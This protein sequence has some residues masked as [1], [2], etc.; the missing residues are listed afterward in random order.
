MLVNPKRIALHGARWHYRGTVSSTV[1]RILR[2]T[3]KTFLWL[4]VALL[5]LAV[6]GTIYQAIATERA[7]RAGRR[8]G[9]QL[10]HRLRGPGQPDGGPGCGLGGNVCRL[11][12]GAAG[13]LPYN[14]RVRLRPRG[15]GME[16]DGAGTQGRQ[17]D[18]RRTPCPAPG[19]Q[20]RRPLR[21]GGPFFR[22]P[23]HADVRRPL[24]RRGGGR[25]PGRV[26]SP[27]TV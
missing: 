3:G 1:R 4:V 19:C 17:A 6:S 11:G 18:L 26:L 5:V 25:V 16:R 27:R 15:D 14:T 23:V 10:A 2:W 20:H 12:L 22:R 9:L 7:E 13:G 24:S 21:A 8:E